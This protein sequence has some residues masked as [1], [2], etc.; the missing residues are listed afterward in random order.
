MH[1]WNC[2]REDLLAAWF[3]FIPSASPVI[4]NK[5]VTTAAAATST[6]SPNAR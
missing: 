1:P 5:G 3:A 4:L 2:L 6:K